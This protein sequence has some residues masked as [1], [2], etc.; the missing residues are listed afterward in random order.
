MSRSTIFIFGA[1]FT[2]TLLQPHV[3]A[4]QLFGS[5]VH[6]G[7]E[8][9]GMI[10]VTVENNST[11]N[12]S[13]EARNNLFDLEHP[14][15]PMTVTNLAG[16][17]ISLVGAEYAYGQLDDSS[18]LPMPSGA[19]WRRELN[20]TSYMPPDTTITKATTNCYA[21]TFPDGFWSINADNLQAGENLATEFL[22]PGASRLVDLSIYSGALHLNIT[23]I[24]AGPATLVATA[25]AIP[26]QAEATEVLGSQ[27]IGILPI[28]TYG[29]SI[30]EYDS[31]ILGD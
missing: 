24:P 11:S 6:S 19:I 31:T 28:Q 7:I 9:D 1:L 14:W 18:F 27:T 12:F 8:S 3:A 15:Q 13:I 17:A 2:T 20:I 10:L 22:K 5:I 29:T 26:Q 21:I 25:E 4:Q 23:S 30:D 16:K